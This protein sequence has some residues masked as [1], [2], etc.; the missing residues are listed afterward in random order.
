MLF[1][2]SGV[3][4]TPRG[5]SGASRSQPPDWW[6]TQTARMSLSPGFE[7]VAGGNSGTQPITGSTP[8]PPLLLP[9]PPLLALPLLLPPLPLVLPPLALPDELPD[10]V[11]STMAIA[12][13]ASEVEAPCTVAP[14]IDMPWESPVTVP[15]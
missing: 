6:H 7:N 5:G 14:M 1:P 3:A 9:P 11:L 8:F 10:C 12:L 13:P 2:L 4:S 15:D